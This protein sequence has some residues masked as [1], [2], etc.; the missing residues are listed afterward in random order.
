MKFLGLR[1]LTWVVLGLAVLGSGCAYQIIQAGKL[2]TDRLAGLEER[3]AWA[4]GLPFVKNLQWELLNEKQTREVLEH[5]VARDFPKEKW[6]IWQ[7]LFYRLDAI[8]QGYKLYDETLALMVDQAA[9]FYDPVT[10]K[11][12]VS[13]KPVPVGPLIPLLQFAMQRDLLNEFVLSH[14]MIHALQDQHFDLNKTLMIKQDR[15]DESLAVHA[16]IEGDALL[17]GVITMTGDPARVEMVKDM[18]KRI[19][20]EAMGASEL[21]K[22]APPVLREYLIFPY[23]GGLEFVQAYVKKNSWQKID[24]VYKQ[25]PVS[26]E[27]ILHPEKYFAG[28]RPEEISMAPYRQALQANWT[29]LEENTLGEAFIG[30]LFAP[31]AAAGWAGDR[32]LLGQRKNGP[33]EIFVWETRWDTPLD[34]VEFDK[35][36]RL[37][38]DHRACRVIREEP[39]KRLVKVR[40]FW[41]MIE[42]EGKVV[43]IVQANDETLV[44]DIMG[45][46]P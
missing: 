26:T 22:K 4:R 38:Q 28:E 25:L 14:E 40:G 45:K 29:I 43:R 16:V 20:Q 15:F 21:L 19:Q 36:A 31:Q 42:L 1:F 12:Y 10:K 18:G 8:P 30:I 39:Q 11:L 13:T 9:A 6:E 3:T 32:C 41:E 24:A 37:W 23:Y 5:A 33:D 2:N 46:R 34:A 44:G 17:G 27:Q 35:A 7:R